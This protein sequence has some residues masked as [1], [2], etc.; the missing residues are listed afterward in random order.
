[1][2]I[3]SLVHG[4]N[5]AL[6]ERKRSLQRKEAS[7]IYKKHAKYTDA[8]KNPL[9]EALEHLLFGKTEKELQNTDAANLKDLEQ[10]FDEIKEQLKEA[11]PFV[12]E[13]LSFTMPEK[14]QKDF[15]RNPDEQTVFGVHLEKL[16]FQRS[17]N[18]ATQK[19]TSHIAMV[20]NGYRSVDEPVFS[21]IA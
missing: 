18:T 16:L 11:A 7:E 9:L 15:A 21:R 2:K 4:S 5:P 17:F 13:D 3:S 19:Y 8:S 14:F 10:P 1:M 6:E 12:N 20:N